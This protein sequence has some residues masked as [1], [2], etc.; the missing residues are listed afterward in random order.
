MFSHSLAELLPVARWRQ[1]PELLGRPVAQS[2][3]PLPSRKRVADALPKADLLRVDTF[4]NLP[5]L[6]DLKMPVSNRPGRLP[7]QLLFNYLADPHGAS[8]IQCVVE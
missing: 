6:K 1:N 7:L 5:A 2:Q 8:P 4:G 3:R